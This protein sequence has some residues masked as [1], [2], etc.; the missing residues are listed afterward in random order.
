MLHQI[1]TKL[2]TINKTVFTTGTS[3]GFGKVTAVTLANASYSVIAGI[4]DIA[5]KNEAVANELATLFNVEVVEIDVTDD[6]SV[7]KAFEKNLAKHGKIDVLVNNAAVAGFGLLEV[8][9]LDKIRQI[10]EV[11][12]YGVVRTYQAVLPTMCTEKSGLI[13]ISLPV[14]AATHRP[15]WCLILPLS[16]AWKALQKVCKTNYDNAISRMCPYSRVFML[17]K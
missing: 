14:P 17:L 11:N 1:T 5:G 4:R 12:F 16:L 13:I 9:S 6:A 8:Y 10:F 15:L 3:T 7:T 2:L